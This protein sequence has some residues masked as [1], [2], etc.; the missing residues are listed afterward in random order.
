MSNKLTEMARDILSI[1]ADLPFRF[2]YREK[3]RVSVDDFELH[4]FEQ[5]WGSTALGFGG[6]GGQAMTSARTYVFVPV[7]CNQK[8][9]VYFN[10]RFAYMAD[11]CKELVEDI[12]QQ[13]M[14]SVSRAGK[15]KAKD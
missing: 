6:I 2:N 12:R 7:T 5:V 11:Y 14:E 8:C 1:E 15:Y 9:I 4:T 3:Q 10:G 13:S